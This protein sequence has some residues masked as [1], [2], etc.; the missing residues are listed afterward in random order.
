MERYIYDG[1]YT[2]DWCIH[3]QTRERWYQIVSECCCYDD[4]C[5][6]VYNKGDYIKIPGDP[7][8]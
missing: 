3:G 8:N 7:Y 1:G 6:V 5:L 2:F 4:G